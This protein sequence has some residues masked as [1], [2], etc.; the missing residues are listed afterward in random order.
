MHY[1]SRPGYNNN[2]IYSTDLYFDLLSV[3]QISDAQADGT[4]PH[5]TTIE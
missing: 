4:V 1:L 5:S 2:K 3:S